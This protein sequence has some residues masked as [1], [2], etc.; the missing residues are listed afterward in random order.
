VGVQTL[1]PQRYEQLRQT[2]HQ[3]AAAQRRES[4]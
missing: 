2:L 1:G 4:T 3:M